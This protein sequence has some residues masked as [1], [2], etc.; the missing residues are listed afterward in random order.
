MTT[1]R[2]TGDSAT[3]R[4]R[5]D[6]ARPGARA[7]ARRTRDSA[8]ER[9]RP[10]AAQ[11]HARARIRALALV[12]PLLL[13]C[14]SP[15]AGPLGSP[16]AGLSE[17]QVARFL[18]GETAF[19]R[20][21]S[22]EEGLGPLFNENQCS[23]CHTF[24]ATG[25]TGEQFLIKATRFSD[26][27]GCDALA[28]AGGEN[29]RSQSTPA[30][31][32][33]GIDGQ[34]FPASATERGRFTVPFLF[35]LGLVE[36]IP[37]GDILSR[38][39]PDDE[40]GDGISGRA[41]R[42][43]DGGIGRFGRKAEAATLRDFI[44]TALRFEMG[45]TT[46]EHPDEGTMGGQPYPPGT[47]P[48]PDP[49]VD[50]AFIE[51]LE[52]FVRYLAP[53]PRRPVEGEDARNVASGEDLFHRAGCSACHT[54]SMRTG[55]SDSPA[56]DRKRVFLY[57]DLL[58]HDMGP[59]LADVC[60]AGAS[61]AEIRTELL[62][63]VGRRRVFLHHGRTIDLMQAILQHGGEATAARERFR[64]LDRVSQEYILQFLRTL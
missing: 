43:P 61:P 3:E 63:G 14:D 36:A 23:A 52:D 39:D 24:P 25:G 44:D 56:L 64:A 27:D 9:R 48:T 54:P 6:A 4:R 17:T 38:V 11:P 49:E 26:P 46:P 57:S 50:D 16:L 41:G 7:P 10:E 31:L 20:I 42:T 51:R 32:A 21:F 1:A 59:G 58:L 13:A 60:G 53:P 34:S 19:N 8:T 28:D 55:P 33:H 22:P 37:E 45:L 5:P 15:A 47:D 62:M 12:L 30:L 2:R 29:V 35:G 18:A 40:D